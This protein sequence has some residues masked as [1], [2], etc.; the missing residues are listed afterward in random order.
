MQCHVCDPAL[1][2]SS[3]DWR[4]CYRNGVSLLQQLWPELLV[5]PLVEQQQLG[6][7]P[8]VVKAWQQHMGLLDMVQERCQGEPDVVSHFQPVASH[9]VVYGDSSLYAQQVLLN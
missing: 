9:C 8:E 5:A 1:Q 3:D 4:S 6:E 2:T 7:G